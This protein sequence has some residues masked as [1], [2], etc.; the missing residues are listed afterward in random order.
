MITLSKIYKNYDNLKV[1]KDVNLHVAK[2]EIYGLIGKNGAGKTTIFKIILGL[3]EFESGT[4]CIAGSKKKTELPQ[5]RKKI[6]F[7]IGNNFY[8]YLTAEENLHYYRPVSYTHLTLP[9]KLEV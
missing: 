3:T 9:T 4:L 5:K 7:F 8:D 1:L 6:G 2:G